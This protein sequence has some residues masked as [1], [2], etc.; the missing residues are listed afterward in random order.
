MIVT[1]NKIL[2]EEY[3]SKESKTESGV[4][5]KASKKK[6]GR[7]VFRV[8]EVGRGRFNQHTGEYIPTGVKKGDLVLVDMLVA[9]EIILNI[10]GENKTYRIIA[11]KEI[12]LI[13]D[14]GDEIV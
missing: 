14:E 9:P 5:Y 12:D 11:E 7:D 3:S 8:V 4:I 10:K 13:L 1:G 6:E 2:I